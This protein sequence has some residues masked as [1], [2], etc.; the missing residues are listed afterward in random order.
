MKFVPA[1]CDCF[2]RSWLRNI[3]QFCVRYLQVRASCASL[4]ISLA[5]GKV[6]PAPGEKKPV[7]PHSTVFCETIGDHTSED[8]IFF[9]T[10][11][12]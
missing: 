12:K 7:A 5:A 2:Q 3:A 10:I 11:K 4:E 9:A 8:Q 6:D 1:T